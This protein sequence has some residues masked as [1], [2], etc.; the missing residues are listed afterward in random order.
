MY[1]R[2]WG[3][4]ESPFQ[5]TLDQRWF[6]GSPQHEEVLARLCYLVEQRR[7]CGILT[8][9]G[10][11]GKSLLL[12]IISNQIR[13]TQRQP[14]WLDLP[15][16]SGGELLWQVAAQLH[17]AP[18]ENEPPAVLWRMIRDQ[19]HALRLSQI[20]TVVLVD[21]IDRAEEDC[22]RMLERLLQLDQGSSCWLTLLVA[23]RSPVLRGGAAGL[24]ERADLRAE[25]VPWSGT[26]TQCYVRESLRRAGADDEV[27]D[28]AALEAIHERTRGIPRNVNRLCDLC[29]LAG[30]A[31]SLEKIDAEIVHSVADELQITSEPVRMPV[32][33]R[34]AELA[35][36]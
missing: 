35:T 16:L 31:E 4:S 6:Y 20:H 12:A 14:V 9:L 26:D 18:L 11:T 33:M 1:E 19:L 34:S 13:R 24:L 27:F 36:S 5:N 15:G 21:R 8:G 28:E 25:L 29:L 7:H 22:A 3:L 32:T 10:G 2:Y 23:T 17:L 30:M